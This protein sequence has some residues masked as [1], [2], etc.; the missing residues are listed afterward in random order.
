ML[1]EVLLGIYLEELSKTATK[2]SQGIPSTEEIWVQDFRNT[3]LERY[4]LHCD[5][6]YHNEAFAC[7]WHLQMWK[8]IL[9]ELVLHF[10]LFHGPKYTCTQ[11]SKWP[12]YNGWYKYVVNRWL[13]FWSL[14]IVQYSKEHNVSET[15]SVSVHMWKGGEHVICWSIR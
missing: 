14:Y 1:S 7:L 10:L 11:A 5:A 15:G 3:K 12:M 9:R 4:L 13:S 6:Q 2:L 8:R